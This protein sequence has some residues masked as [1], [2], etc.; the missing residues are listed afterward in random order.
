[1]FR[2]SAFGSIAESFADSGIRFG[3]SRQWFGRL[4]AQRCIGPLALAE[5]CPEVTEHYRQVVDA[6]LK[7]EG[8]RALLPFGR[9][10]A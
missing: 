2:Q 9:L 6:L 3:D 7:V 8:H 1:M 4:A 10:L 5:S